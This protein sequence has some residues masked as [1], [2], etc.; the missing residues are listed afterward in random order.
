MIILVIGPARAG[1]KHSRSSR[2]LRFM[3]IRRAGAGLQSLAEPVLD[4]TGDFAKLVVAM[5]GVA[6]KLKRGRIMERTARGRAGAKAKG[7]IFGRKPVLTP[8]Q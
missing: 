2:T 3:I 1:S 7:I 5:L 4:T 6:A 8:H